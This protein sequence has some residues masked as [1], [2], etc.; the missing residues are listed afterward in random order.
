[1]LSTVR[2]SSYSILNDFRSV[3]KKRTPVKIPK[4]IKQITISA[5]QGYKSPLYSRSRGS[6]IVPRIMVK[7]L[8]QS[9][10]FKPLSMGGFKGIN[11]EEEEENPKKKK[12]KKNKCIEQ[13][14]MGKLA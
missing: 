6:R 11:I 5:A 8:A 14:W 3:S 9:I 13:H 10:A 12:E 2:R 1:V 7:K 4:I